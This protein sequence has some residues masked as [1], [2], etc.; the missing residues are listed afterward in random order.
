M[1][2]CK[3]CYYQVRTLNWEEGENTHKRKTR[4][5]WTQGIEVLM[6]QVTKRKRKPDLC[7]L[8]ISMVKAFPNVTN[9]RMTSQNAEP[10]DSATIGHHR[11][12]LAPASLGK[13]KA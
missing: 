9:L 1:N 6:N 7:Q 4:G 8:P 10:E 5:Q 12:V 11:P 3:L 2:I 13:G